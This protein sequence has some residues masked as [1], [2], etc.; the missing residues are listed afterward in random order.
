MKHIKTFAAAAIFS[1]LSLGNVNAAKPIDHTDSV[2]VELSYMGSV[3]NQP[4]F[5]LNFSGSEAENEFSISVR[6]AIT[7]K[8]SGKTINYTV[9]RQRK[10]LEEMNI[11]KS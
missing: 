9:N 8:K 2:P 11:V 1:A 5:Q 4:L 3:Q 7:G 10:V 6:F